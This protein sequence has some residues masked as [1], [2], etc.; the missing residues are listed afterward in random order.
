MAP[1]Q[2]EMNLYDSKKGFPKTNPH[3]V[4]GR[5]PAPFR[6]PGTMIPRQWFQPWFQFGAGF[7]PS[8]VFLEDPLYH[9]VVGA[10]PLE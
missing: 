8:T 6:G 4:D 7:C 3:T 2:W 1:E 9:E 10:Q 5:N